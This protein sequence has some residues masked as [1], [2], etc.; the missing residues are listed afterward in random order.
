MLVPFQI[1][2]LTAITPSW[3]PFFSAAGWAGR[4]AA[5][6]SREHDPEYPLGKLR[7]P[8]LTQPA[9][10][11]RLV[12]LRYRLSQ[13]DDTF[14]SF[15]ARL[16][17]GTFAFLGGEVSGERRGLFFDTQ[18]L[19][20][21]LTEEEG[22]Y[23]VEGAYRAPRLLLRARAERPP[24]DAWM[25]DS[26]WA[27]R[28]N[29]DVELLI[30]YGQDTGPSPTRPRTTRPI[31]RGSVGFVYQRG[32]HL[33]LSSEASSAHVHT[34][35]GI[36]LTRNRI[37][38][39][40][41]L[42][43]SEL[44]LRSQFGYEDVTGRTAR[45][46]GFGAVSLDIRLGSHFLVHAGTAN[47]WEPGV[48]MFEEELGAGISFFGRRHHFA[49]E[50]ETPSRT[51]ALARSAFSRGMNERRVYDRDA[52]RAM[53]ERLSLSPGREELASEIDALYRAQVRE[54]NVAQAGLEIIRHTNDVEGLEEM[55]YRSFIAVPWRPRWPFT[56]SENAVDFLIAKYS[57]VVK[58]YVSELRTSSH[59]MTVE[60]ALNR[61]VSLLLRWLE[62]C[63]T[64]TEIALLV[65]PPRRI[66]LEVIY[67]F[68]R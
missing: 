37:D 29:S 59:E 5:D 34:E 49:R 12:D 44:E 58:R 18:R 36:E 9:R 13:E 67:A 30:G 15:E 23:V 41:T 66:D 17:L 28:L 3:Q 26:L 33:E 1:L 27:L 8:S 50:G 16:K 7:F 31:R 43:R 63:S 51:L 40:A 24:D 56:T 57:Y 38:V 55:I 64:P 47:R 48:K 6:E 11:F 20:L 52:L 14:Q 42:F 46:Q 2:L 19:E 60:V 10:P 21:G 62:P 39:T 65:D 54:R 25:L 4:Q 35:G 53:R 61:E 45:E 22:R 68:G 32:S